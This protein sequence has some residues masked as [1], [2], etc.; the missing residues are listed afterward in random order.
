MILIFFYST[1]CGY[2]KTMK[3]DYIAAAEQ[4][5]AEGVR[6]INNI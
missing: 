3:P 5:S 1:G 6:N 4:L 2:C